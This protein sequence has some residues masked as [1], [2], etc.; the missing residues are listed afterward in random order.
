MGTA[1]DRAIAKAQ[2]DHDLI[3]KSRDLRPY[4]TTSQCP[5]NH[6]QTDD[7]NHDLRHHEEWSVISITYFLIMAAM[8]TRVDHPEKFKRFD[9][10]YFRQAD[11]NDVHDDAALRFL[12]TTKDRIED[13]KDY[14]ESVAR[15]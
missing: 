9:R 10:V 11:R 7:D 5:E 1:G 3:T 8:A 13:R 15:G 14:I 2:S 4:Q 6:R 12:D